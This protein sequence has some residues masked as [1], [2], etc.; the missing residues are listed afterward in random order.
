MSYEVFARF[1]DE[2]QGDRADHARYLRGLIELHHPR[3]ETILE[4]ACGTGSV[5]KQLSPR[6]EVTGVDASEEMLR[7]AAEKLPG[8]PLV[9]SDMTRV[10]LAE[11]FD[12]VL[13]VYDSINHLLDFA[14]WEAVFDRARE[15]LE[16]RGVFIVDMNTETKLVRFGDQQPWPQ[17]FGDGHLLLAD[18]KP[19]ERGVSVWHLRIF[20]RLDG[21]SYRLHEEQ[22]PETAFSATRVHASLKER[23]STVRAYDERRAR[24]SARTERLYFVC[25]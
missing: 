3:A 21:S 14:Q 25:R 18:V 11:R 7:I 22:I 16:R 6:Y 5:L 2:T 10:S 19:P 13:C 4:L 17:W 12:V 15:H 9:H 1:Y 8:T 20:E 24:P 23:F